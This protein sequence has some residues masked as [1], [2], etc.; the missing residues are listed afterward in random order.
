MENIIII[1]ILSVIAGGIIGYLISAK[2]KGNKCIGCPYGRSC[3][4]AHRGGCDC[5]K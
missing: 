3:E 4:K 2:R 1:A 5:D